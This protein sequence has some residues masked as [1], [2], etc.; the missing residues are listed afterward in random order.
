MDILEN[1][2][3]PVGTILKLVFV[4]HLVLYIPGDYVILRYSYFKLFG[5]EA[6]TADDCYYFTST[7]AVLGI[8]TFLSCIIQIYY[9]T[10]YGLAIVMGLTGGIANSIFAFILPALI[11]VNVF[12]PDSLEYK[13]GYFLLI[14][15]SCIPFLVVVSIVF[16]YIDI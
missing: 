1:L 10:S 5:G 11:A 9:S 15:G 8:A 2:S 16:Q 4:V 6:S 12:P 3:G 13:C 14:F 7:F